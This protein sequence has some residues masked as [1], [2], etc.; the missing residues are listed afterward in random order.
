MVRIIKSERFAKWK[1]AERAAKE[2]SAKIKCSIC[3]EATRLQDLSFNQWSS[4]EWTAYCETCQRA[5]G[6]EYEM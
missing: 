1:H 2:V 6:D 3:G 5:S 4:R